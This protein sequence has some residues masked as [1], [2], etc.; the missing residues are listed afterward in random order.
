MTNILMKRGNLET[1]M[2][3]GRS[4]CEE[5]G[6]DLSNASTRQGMPVIASKPPEVRVGM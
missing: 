3:I 5:E 2:M 6:G 1:D 4:P